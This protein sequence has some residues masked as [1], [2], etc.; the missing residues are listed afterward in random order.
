MSVHYSNRSH[1]MTVTFKNGT[2]LV[3]TFDE[4]NFEMINVK[5]LR[6]NDLSNIE[7]QKQIFAGSGHVMCNIREA[8]VS[9]ESVLMVA[10]Y[11]K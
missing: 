5:R 2:S 11:R 4:K 3:G 10:A 7:E 8:A 6:L 1:L 9:E